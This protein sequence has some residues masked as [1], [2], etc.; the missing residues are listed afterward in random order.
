MRV[1]LLGAFTITTLAQGEIRSGLRRKARE[2]L[3]FALCHPD[4]F[5]AEQ[6]IEALWPDGDPAKTPD[7]YWNAIANLRRVLAQ[8][9]ATKKLP[10]IVRQGTRYRAEQA[11]FEV[12]LWRVEAALAVAHAAARGAAGDE[13]VMAALGELAS[14]ATG[15]L[16]VDADYDWARTPREEL[17][18]RVADALA[19]LAELRTAAGDRDGALAVLE[20]AIDADPTAEE[21]YRRIMRLQADL[22]RPDAVRRTYHTLGLRLDELDLDPEPATERL[23]AALLTPTPTRRPPGRPTV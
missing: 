23:R 18:R 1:R 11:S 6:A 4:G 12:D 7:W 8:R 20:Q 21:L 22:G 3:A 2:L 16:L 10:S 5:T 9:T 19:R 15:S 14:I 13:Q 17:R